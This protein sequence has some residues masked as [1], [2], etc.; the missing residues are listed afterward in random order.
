MKKA[1]TVLLVL[2]GLSAALRGQTTTKGPEGS[3]NG[4]L[5]AG[6]QTL[7]LVL[8][9][10]KSAD[11]S[12]SGKLD[13]LDQGATIPIDVITVTG[14]SVHLEWKSIEAKFDGKLNAAAT[15]LSG[16][17]SQGGATIPLTLKRAA[18][19]GG[20]A[21]AQA[22]AAKPAAPQ[23]PLDVPADVTVPVPPTA[24][25]G[26]GGKTILCYELHITNFSRS[27]IVLTRA[28]ALS[29]G[30][31]VTKMASYDGDELA[32]RV[33]R[34][35]VAASTTADKLKIGA[36]LRLVIY[37]WIEIDKSQPIP[38]LI[39]HRLSF[40]VG[41]YPEE[42]SV[43]CAKTSVAAKPILISPPLRGSEWLAGNGPSDGSGHR[44]AL[45][46]VGGG[47]HIAQRFAIDFVQLREDGKTFTGD[48][49]DNK[50]YRCYGTD[51]LAVA[52]GVVVATKDGI[53]EN[54]PGENS[55]AVAITLDTV[56]GNHV[57]L[58]LGDGHY[59]FYAHLQP[60]SLRVKQGDKVK[61]GQVLGLVGN[62]GNSTEP[63]LHFHISNSNSPLGSEGLPY[64]LQ[65][66]EVVGKGWGWKPGPSGAASEKRGMEMPLENEV[67]RFPSDR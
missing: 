40:K 59:A 22:T 66:F 2:L 7:R 57:I 30:S 1:T 5:D 61:R 41:D 18:E 28:E 37:F 64:A 29:S 13:S 44:R 55:R 60:G 58:D 23:K 45:V 15:E 27:D 50:N 14:E 4:A 11:G 46:P 47:V 3:W 26:G 10:A 43:Q 17:F 56:G 24:F 42:L 52:D 20:Q 9:V 39:D 63:H 31:A 65:S 53:P 8:T 54:I 25:K 62:S 21:A 16:E 67:V 48:A 12:Y 33:L 51:A 38:S 19:S 49:K 6:G 35:G 34:P 32:K 36:G